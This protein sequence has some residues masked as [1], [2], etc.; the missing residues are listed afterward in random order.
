[1]CMIRFPSLGL[2]CPM[3]ITPPYNIFDA[4]SFLFLL[5][6]SYICV[7]SLLH[8]SHPAGSP[9]IIV[10]RVSFRPSCFHGILDRFSASPRDP[11]LPTS[12]LRTVQHISSPAR[13]IP[14]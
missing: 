11:F 13:S 10:L 8:S 14:G 12:Q 5:L 4:P 1:M 9:A 6:S 2:R 3:I 7:S